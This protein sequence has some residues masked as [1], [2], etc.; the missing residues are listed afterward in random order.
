M[1]VLQLLTL[2]FAY[3]IFETLSQ[4]PGLVPVAGAEIA[5]IG[6]TQESGPWLDKATHFFE[7]SDLSENRRI[8]YLYERYWGGVLPT[9]V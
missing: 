5:Y 7:M 3:S 2:K 1:R 8:P 6:G 4:Q 9:G